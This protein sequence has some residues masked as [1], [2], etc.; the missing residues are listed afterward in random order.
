MSVALA[1]PKRSSRWSQYY[2]LTKPRVVQLIV[3]CA[4]IGAALAVPGL[5][6]QG[7]WL[8]LGL[9]VAPEPPVEA[10]GDQGGAQHDPDVGRPG[11]FA[12][13]IT[14]GDLGSADERTG[15]HRDAQHPPA[16]EAQAGGT[17]SRRVQHQDSGD[18]RQ[19]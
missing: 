13:Q 9:A 10:E 2:A 18:D 6:T 15:D 3:F 16:Q 14:A 8:T 12:V 11:R 7:Q 17:R 4:L 5:P 19:R 1:V